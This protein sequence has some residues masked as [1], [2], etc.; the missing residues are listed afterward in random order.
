MDSVN[1]IFDLDGCLIDSTEVQKAALYGSYKEIVGDEKCPSY[2]EYI[3]Y[4]GDSITNVMKKMNLPLEM[5][6]A[7][8]RISSESID[9]ITVNWELIDFIKEMKSKGSK[10]AICT[11]KDHY[12]VD[13][14]LCYFRIDS[15]FDCIVSSDDVREPKPS[16]EPVLKAIDL[17][18]VDKDSCFMIGDGYNDILSAKNAGIK[19]ILTTWYDNIEMKK[20]ADYVVENVEE[21]RGIVN[22]KRY[23]EC[24]YPL[25][26]ADLSGFLQKAWEEGWLDEYS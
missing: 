14:I 9:K 20:D 17:M 4:T 15:F 6:D 8:R 25:A 23:S 12:R 19:S 1:L 24:P 5:A 22:K 10:I 11:G 3:K 26:D 7:Y 2:E 16:A 13:E 21:L 18:G